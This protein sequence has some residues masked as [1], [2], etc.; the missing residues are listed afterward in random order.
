MKYK[1]SY[2][3][4][5]G[6]EVTAIYSVPC[7]GP[8]NWLELAKTLEFLNDRENFHFEILEEDA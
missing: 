4:R 6:Q 3:V 7:M 8:L 5:P 2:T 1:F